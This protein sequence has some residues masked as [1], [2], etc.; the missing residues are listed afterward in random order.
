[1]YILSKLL[2]VLFGF[3]L[4]QTE[5]FTSIIYKIVVV[6]ILDYQ[7]KGLSLL[8]RVSKY[9]YVIGKYLYKFN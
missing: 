2:V 9:Q 8:Q 4:Y 6:D 5:I 3:D 7:R 1:M